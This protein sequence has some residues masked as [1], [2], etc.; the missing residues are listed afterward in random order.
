MEEYNY[1]DKSP[2]FKF[3]NLLIEKYNGN[4]LVICEKV[5]DI[6]NYL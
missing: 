4:Q 6:C 3:L 1:E 5:Y 2:I